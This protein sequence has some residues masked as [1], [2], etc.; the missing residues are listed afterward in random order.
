M[1]KI[2]AT[3]G[4]SE[5]KRSDNIFEFTNKFVMAASQYLPAL[6]IRAAIN[7]LDKMGEAGSFC[8][9]EAH[10][11]TAINVTMPILHPEVI[12]EWVHA[13]D[14]RVSTDEFKSYA[15]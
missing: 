14:L 10:R 3:T 4:E 9:T 1:N 2:F 6:V 5:I 12:L 13:L 7:N 15:V 8:T 11:T